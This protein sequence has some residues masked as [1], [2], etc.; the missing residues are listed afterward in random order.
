MLYFTNFFEQ[1][2]KG[3]TIK[4][5]LEHGFLIAFLAIFL[6]TGVG[7]L[8]DHKIIH[9]YPWGYMASD[10]FQHQVRA[11]SIKTMGNYKFEAPYIA[12]GYTDVVGFYPPLLYYNSILFSNASNLEIFDGIYLLIFLSA[13][14][15][16]LVFY[17]I[18]KNYNKYVAILSLPLT[19]LIFYKAAFI[20]FTWG[21]WPAIFVQPFLIAL[22]WTCMRFE[23][24]KMWI[25]LGAIASAIMLIH[26]PEIIFGALYVLLFLI[27]TMIANRKST[28]QRV[29]KLACA[30]IIAMILTLYFYMTFRKTWA[31]VFPYKFEVLKTYPGGTPFPML[32]DFGIWLILLLIGVVISTILVIK[33]RKT[34]KEQLTTKY[35]AIIIG[36]FMILIGYGNYYGFSYRAFQI[37][38][39]WPLYLSVFMGIA[40]YFIIKK[41][42]KHFISFYLTA[43]VLL[44]ITSSI[45]SVEGIP[46]TKV[47]FS[48]GIMNPY[49]WDSLQWMKKNLP[50]DARVLFVNNGLYKQDALLRNIQRDHVLVK[51]PTNLV[52]IGNETIAINRNVKITKVGDCCGTGY[53]YRKTFFD[54]G[55]HY[56]ETGGHENR[57]YAGDICKYDYLVVDQVSADQNF[58]KLLGAVHDG[59]LQSK[60]IN[61]VYNNKVVS[62]LENKKPGGNCV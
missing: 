31:I 21:S 1:N 49:H 42:I 17:L 10:A 34:E 13:A 11:E 27:S 35:A 20:G 40:L 44:I 3:V 46:Q 55:Y 4:K 43:I 19:I 18:I 9:P 37:R 15:S 2:K 39:F 47:V 12:G 62:I 56:W 36:L 58:A 22:F 30:S 8:F 23:L 6:F 53:P 5:I 48:P 52:I 41:T 29:N 7:N 54:Y 38:L 32:Q 59:L 57:T 24:D 26:P 51:D 16:V 60:N 33:K 25:S 14:L 61:E 50:Q 45:L 28:I